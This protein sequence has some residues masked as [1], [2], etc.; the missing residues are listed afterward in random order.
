MT[1]NTQQIKTRFHG[2]ITVADQDIVTLDYEILGFSQ[3]RQY[4]LLPHQ[5]NS[6]FLYFQSTEQPELAFITIDPLVR[7]P[8]YRVPPDELPDLGDPRH[9]AVLCLCTI[10]QGAHATINLK[11]PL[12]INQ[13]TRRGGQFVLSL[14]YEHQYPLFTEEPNA[15]LNPEA[16]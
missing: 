8:D 14:P 13:K 2:T 3:Y 16:K 4:I 10:G 5:P 1:E 12:V 9:W 7:F 15:G 11:S 6:P